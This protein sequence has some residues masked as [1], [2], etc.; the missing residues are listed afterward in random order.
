MLPFASQVLNRKS[1][2]SGSTEIEIAAKAL[3]NDRAAVLASKM[4][5]VWEI[6][7]ELHAKQV[8]P[9]H[10]LHFSSL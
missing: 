7:S 2:I 8:L 5:M 10:I 3:K 6:S 9:C 4:A 1:D